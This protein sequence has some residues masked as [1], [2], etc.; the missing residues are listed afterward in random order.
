MSGNYATA[1]RRPLLSL[2]MTGRNDSYMG[3]FKWRLASAVNFAARSAAA[4]GRLEDLEIVVSDWNS[5]VPLYKEVTLVPEALSITRFVYVPPEIAV[6][7]QRDTTFPDSI[8][9][10]TGI[11]R[12]RGEFI[13]MTG[14]DV[15][16]TKASLLV[17]FAVL[18]GTIPGLAVKQAMLTASR[19]HIPVQRIM[20]RPSLA[21]LEAYVHRN[22]SFFPRDHGGAG[23]AAPSN[24]L[25]L[26]RDLWHAC[27]GFDERYIYWGFNDIDLVLRV[28]QRY[29]FIHLDH[30]GVNLLHMEHWTKPRLYVATKMFRKMNPAYN[31]TPEFAANDDGWGL[32]K[33]DLPCFKAEVKASA[34]ESPRCGEGAATAWESSAAQIATEIAA[35]KRRESVQ[36]FLQQFQVFPINPAEEPA[37]W[38]LAWYAD[39][40]QPRNYIETGFRY[41]H[42]A[43]LVSRTSP[44]T[45]LYL[46]VAW[47]PRPEDEELFFRREDLSLLY[48][49]CSSFQRTGHW[50]YTQYIGGDAVTAVR[51][52]VEAMPNPFS[53]DLVLIRGSHSRAVE[54]AVELAEYLS[55]GGAMVVTAPDV[56]RY[57]AI[58][59]SVLGRFPGYFH[60]P[61][62]D[63]I[64]GILLA[65]PPAG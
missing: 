39:Q 2:I 24:M 53:V 21:E 27:R 14:S 49:I 4:I 30:F 52:L 64:N 37:L 29:P 33:H 62:A 28:T 48:Y 12:A 44:G 8:V 38:C 25:M 34:E 7:A 40:H 63:G 6:P 56:P 23:H 45:E 42:A 9:I 54:H 20:R 58:V 46:L 18:D 26:H 65:S 57:Q 51:R 5:E 35:P 32:G 1:D 41:P 55:P 11:R 10:N 36:S 16:Y 43:C 50:A 13:A 31:L 47:E 61:V 3:D 60:L 22:C 59:N 15:L 19:R 17:L